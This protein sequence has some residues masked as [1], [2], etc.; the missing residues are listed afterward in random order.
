M[1]FQPPQKKKGEVLFANKK[2]SSFCF[3]LL[4]IELIPKCVQLL[5]YVLTVQ[6]FFETKQLTKLGTIKW[7][8]FSTEKQNKKTSLML[9]ISSH[10]VLQ[11]SQN[12]WQREISVNLKKKQKNVVEVSFANKKSSLLLICAKKKKERRLVLVLFQKKC[13]SFQES[14]NIYF[15]YLPQ[16]FVC[17]TKQNLVG[18]RCNMLEKEEHVN[19]KMLVFE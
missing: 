10:L 9:Q 11:F 19:K 13:W 18:S 8:N 12:S 4:L 16:L 7:K 1:I 6:V 5:F 14:V 17:P 3:V 15:L 2:S